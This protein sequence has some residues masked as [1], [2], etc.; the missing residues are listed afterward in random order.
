LSLYRFLVDAGFVLGPSAAAYLANQF[1]YLFPAL[2]T[3][4]LLALVMSL[5]LLFLHE[6]SIAEENPK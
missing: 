2:L 1:G 5:T 6:S 3:T 4:G